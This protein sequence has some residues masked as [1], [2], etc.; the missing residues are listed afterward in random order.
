MNIFNTLSEVLEFR[1]FSNL[2]YWIVLAAAWSHASY[3]V[4]SVPFD[5]IRDAQKGANSGDS[6]QNMADIEISATIRA[7]RIMHMLNSGGKASVIGISFL[8]SILAVVGFYYGSQFAQS[9]FLLGFPFIFVG[10]HLIKTARIITS[11]H[12]TGPAMIALLLK[13]RF[14]AQ[15]IGIFALFFA[16]MWGM[17]TLLTTSAIG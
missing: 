17:F 2:W 1:S 14:V 7:R 3:Y 5:A 13:H 10:L 9:V 6:D 15:I 16:I 11:E 8:V 12:P 4:M